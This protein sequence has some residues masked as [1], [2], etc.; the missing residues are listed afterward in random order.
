MPEGLDMGQVGWELVVVGHCF[1]GSRMPSQWWSCPV[2]APRGGVGMG[3]ILG[4][5]GF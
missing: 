4:L 2:Q 5:E 1:M 3:E